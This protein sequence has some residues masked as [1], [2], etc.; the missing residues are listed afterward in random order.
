MPATSIHHRASLL[1]AVLPQ[2]ALDNIYPYQHGVDTLR[3]IRK[4]GPRE[5]RTFMDQFRLL[6]TEIGNALVGP[7][8]A[9]EPSIRCSHMSLTLL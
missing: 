2:K 9:R 5:G 7:H 1:L 4:L 6:L 3:E 8:V